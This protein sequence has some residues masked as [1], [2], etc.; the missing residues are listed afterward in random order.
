MKRPRIADWLDRPGVSKDTVIDNVASF[1]YLLSALRSRA[2]GQW[3]ANLLELSRH[4]TSAVFLAI[5]SMGNHAAAADV[6]CWERSLDLTDGDRELGWDEPLVQLIRNPNNDDST[7]DFLYQIAQQLS[8]TGMA[9][10]WM[11][12][13]T[14]LEIPSELYVIA[15]ASALPWP[16]SPLHPHG[17][18]LI[19]PYYPYG[20]FSTV[21]S[22]QSAAGARIP[23][24][25]I[26][27][28]KN[29]HPFLRYDGYAVLTALNRQIDTIDAID[30]SRWQTQTKGVDPTLALEFDPSIIDPSQ[31]D[32]ARLREQIENLYAGPLGKRIML[33]PVGTKVTKI[34]QSP[35]D[36]AWQE[37][38]SQL[39]DFVLAAYG[40]PKAVAG[41]QDDVSYSTLYSSLKQYYTLSLNPLLRKIGDKLNKHLVTPFFGDDLY[42]TLTG[43][44]I[45][46]A[47]LLERQLATDATMGV[48]K[49]NE[50]RK[51]RG[52]EPLE[53]PEGEELVGAGAQKATPSADPFGGPTRDED[54]AAVEN[55]RP[56][57]TVSEGSLPPKTIRPNRLADVL[58]RYKTNGVIYTNGKV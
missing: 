53:G 33:N 55:T 5:N 27:R 1:E 8:L 29:A 54:F 48:R 22:C 49:R 42:V 6:K 13:T 50:I 56:D 45:E 17:S 4:F 10:V 39:V 34:S 36:M 38:W 18:Y 46:D 3:S 14:T 32:M 47:D 9:L 30:L 11:P 43:Q 12:R 35:A 15:S 58:E 44:Q 37:G 16:P 51:L 2:P 31:T 26:I 52:L 23:A 28:I 25:Q 7:G 41:L 19:Q 21:P 57:P 20:P 40:V 24:E